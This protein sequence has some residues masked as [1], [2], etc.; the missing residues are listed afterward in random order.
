MTVTVGNGDIPSLANLNSARGWVAANI[1]PFHPQ[2]RINRI[3]VGNEIM[4]TANKP[5]IS[6]LVPAMRTIHKALVLAGITN[7]Q[8]L[9]F[10]ITV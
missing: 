4:A 10:L 5:W 2:T 1:A 9:L 7:V 8:V 6:N 3:V